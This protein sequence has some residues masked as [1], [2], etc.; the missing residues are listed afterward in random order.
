[1]VLD[2]SPIEAVGNMPKHGTLGLS[3]LDK[4]EQFAAAVKG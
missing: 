1:M 3:P 2:D 4:S